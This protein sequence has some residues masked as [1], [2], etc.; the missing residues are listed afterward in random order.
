MPELH[1]FRCPNCA[2]PLPES[3]LRAVA[4][5]GFCGCTLVAGRA[6]GPLGTAAGRA[7]SLRDAALL[8]E[9]RGRPAVSV[10]G[11][12]VLLLGRAE[13]LGAVEVYLG[14]ADTRLTELLWVHAWPEGEGLGAAHAEQRSLAA[15]EDSVAQGVDYF[16]S[17]LP[18]LVCVGWL[19]APGVSRRA[20]SVFRYRSGLAHSLAELARAQREA[21]APRTVAWVACRALE[22]L[23]WLHASGRTH[24]AVDG[25]HLLLHVRARG[26]ALRGFAGSRALEDA[27]SEVGAELR[28]LGE[29]LSRAV[30]ADLARGYVPSRVPRPLE[31]ALRS[32]AAEGGARGVSAAWAHLEVFRGLASSLPGEAREVTLAA[33]RGAL[34]R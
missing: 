31:A 7:T 14:R 29:T 16:R 10:Q 12:R 13:D 19:E 32:L 2:A 27:P 21:L 5:C 26:A 20:A 1:V 30:G 23:G 9:A 3:A 17:L 34:P 6:V 33:L 15:L 8:R 22:Q 18:S 25:Q 11:R 4:R 28:A 24:G